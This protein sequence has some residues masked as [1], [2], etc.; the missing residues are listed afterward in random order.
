MQ[1]SIK[2]AIKVPIDLNVDSKDTIKMVKDK[3][4]EQEGVLPEQQYLYFGKVYLEDSKTL[5]N[6]NIV[7]G[8][9]LKM[10]IRLTSKTQIYIKSIKT[11]ALEVDLHDTILAVKEKIQIQ[12]GIPPDQQC[13]SFNKEEL[14][15]T[16][17]LNHYCV[18]K[19]S[20]LSLVLRLKKPS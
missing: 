10:I 4:C 7:H 9:S 1:I 15:D 18:M 20:V 11:E 3:I 8:D 19:D 17:T 12:E 14:D 13:L 16:K 5:N 2:T 6:Y